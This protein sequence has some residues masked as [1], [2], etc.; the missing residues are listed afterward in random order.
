MKNDKNDDDVKKM[1]WLMTGGNH[2]TRDV[3]GENASLHCG[4]MYFDVQI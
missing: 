3:C 1:T 2:C 4:E